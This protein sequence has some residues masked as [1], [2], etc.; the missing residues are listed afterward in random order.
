M[1]FSD[2]TDDSFGTLSAFDCFLSTLEEG[3]VVLL[4]ELEPPS[5]RVKNLRKQIS[6]GIPPK[7]VRF[8][9][10]PVSA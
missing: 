8:V 5:E 6:E 1:D 2:H 9:L 10:T 7:G 3:D 4:T